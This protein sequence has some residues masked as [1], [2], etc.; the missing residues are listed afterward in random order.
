[1]NIKI[2]ESTYKTKENKRAII[3]DCSTKNYRKKINTGIYIED[4][5]LD[6]PE[7]I[8]TIALNITLEKLKDKKKDALA[9]YLEN[10]WSF[11]ELENYL[12]KGI[13]IYSVDEYVKNDFVKNKNIITGNDYFNVIKVIKKHL[14]KVNISFN[15]LL[16]GNTILEFKLKAQRN[17]VKIS[18]VNSYIKKIGVIMNQAYRDGFI[19]RRFVIPKYVLEHRERRLYK[20]LFDKDKFIEAINNSDN[21]FQ[22]QSLSVFLMLI[23]CGGMKPSDLVNY[24]VFNNN[25]R[26]DLLGSMIYDDNSRFLKFKKSK[27]GGIFKYA[28]L[29]YIKIKIIE[30]VKTLFY[31]THHKKYPHIIS[32]YSN[33]YKIF[34]FN[35]EKENNLYRNLWNFYQARIKEVYHLKFSDAK[36]IYYDKLNE[37]EMNKITSDILFAKVKEIELIRLQNTNILNENIEK[38]ENKISRILSANEL[39]Q[40]IKNKL[41]FLGV[42]LNRISL[43]LVKTPVEFSK[44]LT[45]INKYHKGL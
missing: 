11:S 24:E 40:I 29:D 7:I 19:T 37:I 28:K 31:I 41:V 30:L 1:M 15:D 14:N 5:Y 36:S 12:S 39:L 27:K 45:E 16:D 43:S 4:G 20:V 8:L 23:I 3:Y 26:N 18:S 10:N 35:I 42:D 44:F 33:Q 32:S 25:D 17:G 9:K 38:C 22:V 2:T 13:D 6:N 34:D 21:I